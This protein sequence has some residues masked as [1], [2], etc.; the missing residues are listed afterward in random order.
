MSIVSRCGARQAL[1]YSLLLNKEHI[2]VQLKISMILQFWLIVQ[3]GLA[4]DSERMQADIEGYHQ[5]THN[6]PASVRRLDALYPFELH[7]YID[8][9]PWVSSDSRLYTIPLFYLTDS[10]APEQD[11]GIRHSPTWGDDAG[12]DDLECCFVSW[13]N[14]EEG[15]VNDT[16]GDLLGCPHI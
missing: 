9:P 10:L 14:G 11:D 5:I 13:K 8:R 4:S 6:L 12:F 15:Q 7:F 3:V 2:K 1:C 16:L